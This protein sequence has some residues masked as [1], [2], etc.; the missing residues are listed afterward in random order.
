MIL[1]GIVFKQLCESIIL[2]YQKTLGWDAEVQIELDDEPRR[3]R[4]IIDLK[5]KAKSAGRLAR[6]ESCLPEAT[7]QT[8]QMAVPVGRRAKG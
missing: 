1:P 2:T 8:I 3:W 5:K 6:A 7:C 4:I